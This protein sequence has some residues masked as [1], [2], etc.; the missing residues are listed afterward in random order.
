M[1]LSV[2][3]YDELSAEELYEILKVRSDVFVVEQN[4]VYQDLDGK[5][6]MAYH[7][8]I[9]DE[10]KIRAYLRVLAPGVSFTEVSLGRV[11]TT[12]RN[13]GY[14]NLILKA[15]IETAVEKYGARQIRIEAQTYAKGFYEKFGF[16]QVSEE[17][18]EDGIPHIQM[19][20]NCENTYE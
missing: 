2:K 12:E 13:K 5:D 11:L 8:Y 4:C 7:V 3:K 9:K 14:G 19:L 15:G 20:L 6:Q 1:E 17:F 16:R 10:Q 18:L